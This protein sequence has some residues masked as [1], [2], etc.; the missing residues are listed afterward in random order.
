MSSNS[1]YPPVFEQFL[2]VCERAEFSENCL[3]M[4]R[5]SAHCETMAIETKADLR[6]CLLA[7]P[8]V[9]KLVRQYDR[10]ESRDMCLHET[11]GFLGLGTNGQAEDFKVSCSSLSLLRAWCLPDALSLSLSSSFGA[12][13]SAG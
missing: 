7:S 2:D 10:G 3:E 5:D 8:H 13:A 1:L 12:R 4:V 11:M 6:K 9:Q